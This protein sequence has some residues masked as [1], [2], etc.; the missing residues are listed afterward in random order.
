MS[1]FKKS[2]AHKPK[3]GKGSYDRT[4]FDPYEHVRKTRQKNYKDSCKLEGIEIPDDEA[5]PNGEWEEEDDA[6]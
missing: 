4:D 1:Y 3:K 6:V 5:P 2:H